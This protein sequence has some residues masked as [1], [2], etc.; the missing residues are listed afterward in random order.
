MSDG[1]PLN[2]AVNDSVKDEITS[3]STKSL[4]SIAKF[5]QGLEDLRKETGIRLA[6][7]AA[8]SEN[9]NGIFTRF[10]VRFDGSYYRLEPATVQVSVRPQPDEKPEA[11]T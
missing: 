3:P 2:A 8:L 7:K 1:S 5:M 10:C 9:Y 6:S 11:E 4:T